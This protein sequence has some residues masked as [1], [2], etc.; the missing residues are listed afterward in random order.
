MANVT[1][2][3]LAQ[4]IYEDNEI[5]CDSF[6]TTQKIDSTELTASNSYNPYGVDLEKESFEWELS[7]VASHHRAFFQEMWEKQQIDPNDL[8][9]VATFDYNPKTGDIAEDDTYDGV[10]IT[11][12][13]KESANK[14]FSVK[15]GALRKL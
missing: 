10:Y 14:P 11:E 1:R 7:D 2:Y 6:K 8:A 5:T 9:M 3:N 4:F 13:S 12:I 15:G